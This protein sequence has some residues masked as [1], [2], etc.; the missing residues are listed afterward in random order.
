VL[1]I[2][3][4]WYDEWCLLIAA[5]DYMMVASRLEYWLTVL[6]LGLLLPGADW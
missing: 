5:V 3:V 1:P 2:I 6:L 4:D